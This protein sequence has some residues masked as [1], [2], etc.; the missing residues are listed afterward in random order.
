MWLDIVKRHFYARDNFLWI[1]QNGPLDLSCAQKFHF[2]VLKW[3]LH[4]FI[5]RPVLTSLSCAEKCRFTVIYTLHRFIKRGSFWRISINLSHT[6]KCH[7]TIYVV[8]P[9][10]SPL[11]PS[12]SPPS[13]FPL[14]PVPGTVYELTTSA[15][16]SIDSSFYG[17]IP[18]D[19][20]GTVNKKKSITVLILME[21]MTQFNI[22]N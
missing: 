5:K 18:T 1:C 7:F 11:P 3:N 4:K 8:P 16:V 17:D 19:N 14:Q 21:R 10:P 2:T 20:T 12:T 22:R 15:S 6:Q 13:P 9:S